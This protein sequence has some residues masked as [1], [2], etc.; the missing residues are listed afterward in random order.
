MATDLSTL[1]V[2]MDAITQGRPELELSQVEREMTARDREM[3]NPFTKDLQVTAI[4]GARR[5]LADRLSRVAA[6]HR[7]LD[8]QPGPLIAD[9]LS[10]LT[11]KTLGGLETDLLGRAIAA[12]VA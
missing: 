12:A 1:A 8:P 7:L 9:R 5:Y 11:R 3:E 4:R 2:E 6:P 10:V